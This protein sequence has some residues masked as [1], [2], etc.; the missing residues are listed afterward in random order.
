MNMILA[1]GAAIFALIVLVGMS[2]Y[3]IKTIST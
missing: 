2:F 3:L 1:C